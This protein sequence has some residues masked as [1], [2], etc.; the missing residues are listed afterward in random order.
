MF[1][2]EKAFHR[3][4]PIPLAQRR[5]SQAWVSRCNVTLF[6]FTKCSRFLHARNIVFKICLLQLSIDKFNRI[7]T[8]SKTS[9]R[10][11]S[12]KYDCNHWEA[13]EK[14]GLGC[15]GVVPIPLMALDEGIITFTFLDSCKPILVSRF[16]QCVTFMPWTWHMC[17][18]YYTLEYFNSTIHHIKLRCSLLRRLPQPYTK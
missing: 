12:I 11:I 8:C 6:P 7:I 14:V 1:W 13:R 4:V 16:V 2:Y 3:S 18:H 17:S 5:T 10:I 9:I 15:R